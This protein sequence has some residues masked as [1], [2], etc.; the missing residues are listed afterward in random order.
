MVDLEVG[1]ML[2][3]PMETTMPEIQPQKFH[4]N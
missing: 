1:Y 4:F 3:S 2:E